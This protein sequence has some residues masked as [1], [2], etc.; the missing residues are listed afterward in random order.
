M[1]LSRRSLIAAT[2][3]ASSA[4]AAP[5][6][7]AQTAPSTALPA[8]SAF[9]D[10]GVTYLNA[11]STHPMPL[12]ARA[13]CEAY[14]DIKTRGKN[15]PG[16]NFAPTHEKVMATF[17][18]LVGAAPDELTLIQSTTMG[19]CLVLQ[20]LGIPASGG[21]IVT[22]VLHYSGSFYTYTELAK[23]GMDVVTLPM[24]PEGKIAYSGFE[25]AINDKTKLVAI[26]S[27]SGTN[28]FEHDLKRVCDIAH[29]HGA[30]VYVDLIQSA[31]ANPID[32]R[33]TGVDFAAS[34][35]YKFLMGDFGLG[36]LYVRREIQD[37]IK[38]PWFGHDQAEVII[39]HVLPFDEPAPV[40]ATYKMFPG[41]EGLFAMGT[42]CRTGEVLLS[43]SLPWI[44]DIGA[45]RIR[46]WRQPMVDAIQ[47]EL[48]ARGYQP[49]TP[50]DS[51]TQIV[52]FAVKDAPGRLSAPLDAAKVVVTLLP[53]RMRI[54]VSVF[55]DMNDID[56]LLA[57]LPARA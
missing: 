32:L 48:R 45:A 28:G 54:A 57:A 8:K 37:K 5:A 9:A 27:V 19:E 20:A 18:E 36:F 55:N 38:R 26:T 17:G 42:T 43:S 22:D 53:N 31:G 21:R 50:L 30:Y 51:K 39:P 24:T 40:V 33:A 16:G 4:A 14:L 47:K 44:R 1:D 41:A 25:A 15:G 56:R 3:A 2:A 23:A 46:A 49:L 10:M 13:A 35:T 11:A 6:A 7:L 12:A 29:A 34:A 52:A